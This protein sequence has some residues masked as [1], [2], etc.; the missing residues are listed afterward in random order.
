MGNKVKFDFTKSNS[1]ISRVIQNLNILKLMLKCENILTYFMYL[2]LVELCWKKKK[3]FPNQVF[4][5]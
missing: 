1:N 4:V 2:F 5:A 3:Y